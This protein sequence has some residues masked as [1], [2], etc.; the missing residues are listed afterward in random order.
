MMNGELHLTDSTEEKTYSTKQK[1]IEGDKLRIILNYSSEGPGKKA[2]MFT[3]DLWS[4]NQPIMLMRH[5]T[6][7]V[8]KNPVEDMK[9][10][11]FMDFDIGG[12]R[13]YKDDIG[14]YDSENGIM[15]IWDKSPLYVT[16]TSRP[17]P[18]AWDIAAPIKL[19]VKPT[20][21]DL[22][23]NLRMDMKDIASGMQWNIGNIAPKERKSVDIVL[24]SAVSLDEV[25]SLI[26][27]G[28]Q[29]FEK[30]MQ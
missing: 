16:M 27:R 8:S 20:H 11:N 15:M 4:F 22:K 29:F 21:R 5:T 7:N 13:S 6:T 26:S 23:N 2:L 12:T 28:W 10:Y 18:D 3:L 14:E 30:K 9:V 19:K 17:R 24:T 25:K 1:N